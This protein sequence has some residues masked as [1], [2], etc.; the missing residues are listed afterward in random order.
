MNERHIMESGARTIPNFFVVGAAKAATTTLHAILDRHPEVY[1]P[2]LK[3]PGYFADANAPQIFDPFSGRPPFDGTSYVRGAMAHHEQVAYIK[4][5]EIYRLL[6]RRVGGEKAVGDFST[7]YLCSVDAAEKIRAFNPAA[8]IIVVLREPIERA[9]SHYKM[10]QAIG[11]VSASFS[12]L[13]RAELDALHDTTKSAPW[14]IR[15]GLYASQVERFLSRFPKDQVKII[16]FE[17]FCGARGEI[18]SGIETFL[19]VT[20]QVSHLDMVVNKSEQPRSREIVRLIERMNIR[21]MIRKMVPRPVI[22]LGKRIL[23]KPY[24]EKPAVEPEV[25][26]QV[27][28]VVEP[29]VRRLGTLINRDL[30]HWQASAQRGEKTTRSF[31]ASDS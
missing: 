8:K 7:A 4:D 6:Y 19:E 9:L 10:D 26:A 15:L 31:A 11:L 14:Y 25:L 3:E 16:L 20:P 28:E 17:D 30:S 2:P 5:A 22:D 12:E 23:Y 21:P 13:V 29:D 18:I 1:C 27:Q 24:K